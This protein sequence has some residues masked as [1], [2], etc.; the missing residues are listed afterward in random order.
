ME[1]ATTPEPEDDGYPSHIV[2]MKKYRAALAHFDARVCETMAVGQ[3]ISMRLSEPHIGYGTYVFARIC[4]QAV[5]MVRAVPESRWVRSSSQVWDV[6]AVASFARSIIEGQQLFAYITQPPESP[7]EWATRINV[8][9]L[10]DCTKRIRV[11]SARL[12]KEELDAFKAQAEE[13]RGRLRGNPW[14]NALKPSLQEKLLRG[15]DLTIATR[16]EQLE[17]T[18]WDKW[19]FFALWDILSQYAHVLPFSFYRMEHNGRGTGL[20]NDFDRSY[21]A[22]FMSKCSVVLADCVDRMVVMFPDAASARLGLNSKFSP[23][24]WRN[25]PR[26]RKLS[27]LMKM[28]GLGGMDRWLQGS[29]TFPQQDEDPPA[30]P[31]SEEMPEETPAP[32]VAPVVEAV[33]HQDH[34]PSAPLRS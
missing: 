29:F 22:L 17:L 26:R 13:L 21:L 14:F 28:V 33:S 5:C 27:R 24:P 15:E 16:A 30:F 18:G 31:A 25:L 32:E 3:A 7:E 10:Y 11:L 8:M 23:G 19:E 9:H 6:A 12:E 4:T 2:S 34:D 20:N 1:E